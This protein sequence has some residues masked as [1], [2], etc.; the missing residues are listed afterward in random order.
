MHEDQMIPFFGIHVLIPLLGLTVFVLL[1]RKMQRATQSPPFFPYLFLFAIF[2][3]WLM[4]CLTALFWRWSGLASIGFAALVLVAPL[5]TAGLAM[6]LR[7][8]RTISAFHRN[9]YFASIAYCCLA[10]PALGWLVWRWTG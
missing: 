1:C 4:I 8:R 5:G 6:R 9:A 7:G 2:G 3:G 10:F